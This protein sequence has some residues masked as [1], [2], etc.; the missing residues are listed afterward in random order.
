MRFDSYPSGTGLTQV[1][2]TT[3]LPEVHASEFTT[4][5]GVT[6]IGPE[7]TSSHVKAGSI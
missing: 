5:T 2:Y 6:H 7:L 4:W 1:Q 3:A